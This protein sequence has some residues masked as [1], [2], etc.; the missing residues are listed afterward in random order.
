M[1]LMDRLANL[2]SK[3]HVFFPMSAHIS[4]HEPVFIQINLNPEDR[5]DATCHSG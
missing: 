5:A 1:L 3:C 4:F 2:R